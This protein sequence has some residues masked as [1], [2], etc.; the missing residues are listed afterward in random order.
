[1]DVESTGVAGSWGAFN[2][3]VIDAG[4]HPVAPNVE[5]VAGPA[6][7]GVAVQGEAHEVDPE[8]QCEAQL[9]PVAEGVVRVGNLPLATADS[10]EVPMSDASAHSL[11]GELRGLCD[12]D[13]T[14]GRSGSSVDRGWRQKQKEGRSDAAIRNRRLEHLYRLEEEGSYFTLEEMEHRCPLLFDEYVGR[15]MS[16]DERWELTGSDGANS[17][18]AQLMSVISAKQRRLRLEEERDRGWD[19]DGVPAERPD[20]SDKLDERGGAAGGAHQ[21]GV[22]VPPRQV[23]TDGES[24]SDEDKEELRCEFE[25][26]MR[27]RFLAGLDGEHVD[28]KEV[29]LDE[30]LDDMTLAERDAQDAWFEED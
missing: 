29:D 18:A 3:G 15:Y 5:S 17:W 12:A 1:M 19:G 8:G 6:V 22:A 10:G 24:L 25:R 11:D 20:H 26:L 28:Y 30:T 21:D 4:A 9:A 2:D 13:P 27:E 16:D 7:G 14:V 23:V